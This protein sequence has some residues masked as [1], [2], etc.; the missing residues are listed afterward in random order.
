MPI[1]TMLPKLVLLGLI[2]VPFAFATCLW[3]WR[4]PQTFYR[5]KPVQLMALL[6]FVTFSAAAG[7]GVIL[8][9]G[10]S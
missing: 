9:P 8:G 5:S 1:L 6:K 7:I 10:P 3:T 4:Q 2:A